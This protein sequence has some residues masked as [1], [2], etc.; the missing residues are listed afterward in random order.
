ML[1]TFNFPP[2]QV[3][4]FPPHPLGYEGHVFCEDIEKS[5][6]KVVWKKTTRK[7]SQSAAAASKQASKQGPLLGGHRR[8]TLLDNLES[9]TGSLKRHLT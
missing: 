2:G 3:G 8:L 6:I 4:S 5:A 1:H 9:V 7:G